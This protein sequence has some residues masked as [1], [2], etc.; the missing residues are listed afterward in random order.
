YSLVGAP[1]VT[2]TP[3]KTAARTAA[4]ATCSVG[5]DLLAARIA[6]R[7]PC[8]G[9][10]NRGTYLRCARDAVRYLTTAHLLPS[11]CGSGALDCARKSICGR[12]H[13]VTCCHG[14]T[15][16]IERDAAACTA[17]GGVAGTQSS[18]CAACTTS[19]CF[20]TIQPITALECQ[21]TKLEALGT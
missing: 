19:S 4:P 12:R 10:P 14:A 21:A 5:R 8:A 15:C 3:A 18:C 17:R 2:S 16:R 13:A 9:A 20:P 6:D 7:C 1:P 11:A